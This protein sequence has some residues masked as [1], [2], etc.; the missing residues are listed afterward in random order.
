MGT[1]GY[2]FTVTWTRSNISNIESKAL[3]INNYKVDVTK[4]LSY[5][6]DIPVITASDLIINI[7]PYRV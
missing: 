4:S 7:A 5:T 6:A 3:A 2:N 1:G